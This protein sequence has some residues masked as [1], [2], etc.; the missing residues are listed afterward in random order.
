MSQSSRPTC[1]VCCA[2]GI[3]L[4]GYRKPFWRWFC[5]EHRLG[6][7]YAD[8]RLLPDQLPPE[9]DGGER[10]DPNKSR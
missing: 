9:T 10:H 5:A 1:E 4:S 7:W 2:S 3:E 8:K 6:V